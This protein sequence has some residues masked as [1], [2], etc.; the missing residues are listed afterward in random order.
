LPKLDNSVLFKE[1]YNILSNEG[2][3]CIFPEGT[4]HDRP[5]FIKLKAGIAFMSLGAMAEYNCKNVKIVP[6]GLNYF[7]REKFRSDVNIEFGKPFE[8]PSQWAEEFKTNKRELRAVLLFR[9]VYVPKSL[10]LSPTQVSELNKRFIKGYGMLKEE[11]EIKEMLK[12]G[13]NYITEIDEL[14]LEDKDVLSTEF[15]HKTMKRKFL[16]SVVLFFCFLLFVTP[17]LLIVL[18]FIIYVRS[19]AEKERI[20]VSIIV[21]ITY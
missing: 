5:D 15:E 13:A 18:P 7:N 1:A 14:G 6:V 8:V 19:I 16:L 12:E 3:I 4:S 20:A 2:A 10:N 21:K 9:N 17:G 11:P